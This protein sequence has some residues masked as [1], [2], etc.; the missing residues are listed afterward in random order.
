MAADN[1]KYCKW[2]KHT[3][4]KDALVCQQCRFGQSAL[5]KPGLTKVIEIASIVVALGVALFAWQQAV[6]ASNSLE[7]SERLSVK[8]NK[9]EQ[10]LALLD[11]NTKQKVTETDDL[12]SIVADSLRIIY[13]NT[14]AELATDKELLDSLCPTDLTEASLR[15]DCDIRHVDFSAKAV[16]ALVWFTTLSPAVSDNAYIDKLAAIKTVCG[17]Q[18]KNIDALFN[19]G[20][21]VMG[22]ENY[23]PF[24]KITEITEI[25]VQDP[26]GIPS[27]AE[28]RKAIDSEV[29]ALYKNVSKKWVNAGTSSY[30]NL[31]KLCN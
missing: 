17:Y 27:E 31:E 14:L 10:Q 13:Q 16:N 6:R 4:L 26:E 11:I 3:M 1:L 8:F 2:C 30:E 12:S 15:L 24:Q 25:P 5:N 7:Q 29:I 28:R 20:D 19:A 22:L 9:Q 18:P 21:Y 23:V